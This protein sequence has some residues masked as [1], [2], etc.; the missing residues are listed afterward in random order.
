LA[1]IS[2]YPLSAN[3]LILLPAENSYLWPRSSLKADV[4]VNGTTVTLVVSH[5]KAMDDPTS[6]QKRINQASAMA[7]WARSTYPTTIG[8]RPIIFA[9][10]MNT[11]SAGDRGSNAATMGYLQLLDNNPGTTTD[12]FWAANE[13]VLPTISTHVMG[14]VLD[15]IIL[16]PGAEAMYV[17]GSAEVIKA[18]PGFDL[19]R[20]E[21]LSDHYMVLIELD[22]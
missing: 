17:A 1:I 7:S 20:L 10:D 6:L 21:T 13:S 16:S 12:D 22:I 2:K 3:G 5:L 14:S 19:E 15:H 11:V 8:T 4:T 9:G 18:A